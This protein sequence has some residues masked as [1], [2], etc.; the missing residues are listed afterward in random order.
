MS[1]GSTFF[2][3]SLYANGIEY[4]GSA[5]TKVFLLLTTLNVQVSPLGILPTCDSDALGLGGA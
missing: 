3:F 1:G 4:Q 5:L 2:S